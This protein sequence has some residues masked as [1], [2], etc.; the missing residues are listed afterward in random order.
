MA[1][2]YGNYGHNMHG[3]PPLQTQNNYHNQQPYSPGS[4]QQ[5]PGAMSPTGGIPPAKRQRLS[6]QPKSPYGSPYSATPYAHSPPGGQHL[7]LPMSPAPTYPPQSFHQP[8]PYHQP[9]DPNA[10]S[11]V[12][13][14]MPPPPVPPA[15][16][17]DELEKANARDMD[18]NNISDVLTGSGIDL[19][20]E[21]DFLLAPNRSFNSQTTN[22][23]SPHGSFG[24]WPSGTGAHGAFHGVGPLSQSVTQ[25]EQENE[26]VRKHTMAARALAEANQAPLNDP[27]LFA[28]KLRQRVANRTY[29]HGISVN[30]EGLYDKIPDT[31]RNVTRTSIDGEGES[32]TELTADSLLNKGAPFVDML[33]LLSLAAE[34]R[35]RTLLEDAFTLS[36]GRQNTADGVIDPTFLDVAVAGA[37]PKETTAAP[38]NISKTAWEAAPDSAVSP[39]TVSVNKNP[40]TGRLPTPPTDAPP[41]PQPTLQVTNHVVEAL[42]RKASEDLEYERKR[43]AKRKKRAEQAA[44]GTPAEPDPTPLPIDPTKMSKK[45]RDKL[46]KAGQTDE[47]LHQQANKT[48]SIALG[49]LGGKK[50]YSWMTG[51]GGGLGSGRASGTSTPRLNTAVGS[52]SGAAT[53]AAPAVD[54]GLI[55]RKRTFGEFQESGTAG[56][57]IQIRDLIHVLELDGKERKTL[58]T[59]LAKLKNTEKD[60]KKALSQTA[61]AR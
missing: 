57:N 12:Q 39:M 2:N 20:A 9:S 8:Q 45:E 50:K 42:K 25:E 59:M 29:E 27:F 24:A 23:L 28:N 48:A 49:G 7:Q 11:H 19:R 35:V 26:L 54:R 36:Q 55:G 31:P 13:N 10:R 34:D 16:A 53:P 38:I 6:P 30:L 58:A 15:K 52:G 21:E 33:S 61:Q 43:I 60:E 18:V 41:T 46:N 51:G 32:I 56:Q 17:N 40:Q 1:N 4:Y 3:M 5:S 47:V 14:S 22:T 37:Q 44:G